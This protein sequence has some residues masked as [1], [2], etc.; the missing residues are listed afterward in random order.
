M[1]KQYQGQGQNQIQTLLACFLTKLLFSY[2]VSKLLSDNLYIQK[3]GDSF[4]NRISPLFIKK[5]RANGEQ[6]N[7]QQDNTFL[8][9]RFV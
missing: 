1:V 7:K 6:V 5:K 9:K 8:K 4:L 2:S 3:T